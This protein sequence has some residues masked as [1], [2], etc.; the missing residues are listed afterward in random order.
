MEQNDRE[1]N[2]DPQQQSPVLNVT[3]NFHFPGSCFAFQREYVLGRVVKASGAGLIPK[4][5]R[6]Y[7]ISVLWVLWFIIILRRSCVNSTHND[8]GGKNDYY[9]LLLLHFAGCACTNRTAA[10][11]WREI[12]Y[13]IHGECCRAGR[14][15]HVRRA[16]KKRKTTVGN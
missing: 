10:V 9:Y 15:R 1:R 12:Q 14:K 7:N 5:E 3:S 2:L 16:K 4:S 6:Q 11:V 13:E 8:Y